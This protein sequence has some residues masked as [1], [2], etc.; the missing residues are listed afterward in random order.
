MLQM[1]MQRLDMLGVTALVTRRVASVAIVALAFVL[2][3]SSLT[4]AKVQ[5]TYGEMVDYQLTFPVDGAVRLSDSFYAA[6]S[7]GDHHAQDL[8]APKMTP[9]VAA[10]A[11]TVRYVNWSRDP[12]NLNP[13]RC[14]TMVIRHDDGW[15]SWYIHLNND[16]PGTDDGQA[17]G[18]ADGIIPG[19]RVTAGQHIG[20][21]GDSG[22]AEGTA[23]HLHFE[24][25]DPDGVI[26]NPYQAL[27]GACGACTTTSTGGSTSTSTGGTTTN[28]VAGPNDTLVLGSRGPVVSEVQSSLATHGFSPGSA[29]GIF[30]GKTFAAV[31]AFQ[32]ARGLL[33]DGKVGPATKAALASEVQAQPSPQQAVSAPPPAAS[34][35]ALVA[36]GTR[37]SSVIDL[38]SMLAQLG[39]DP[40]GVDGA[41]GPLTLAAIKRFQQANGLTD[42][43]TVGQGTWDALVAAAGSGDETVTPVVVYGT[44]SEKVLKL[45]SMLDTLGHA[46]GPVDGIF[47]PKTNAAVGRFQAA[48]G[49]SG[50]LVDQATWDAL[51]AAAG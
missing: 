9:V 43:G 36:Y 22:N 30:G 10:A 37:G 49:F 24:L 28:T 11:G 14:C 4:F 46:P 33:V 13:D 16:T 21:V 27:V 6:R 35:G 34:S 25:Y 19:A 39:H 7:N 5:F 12:S 51:V 40:G 29:D 26:V 17:W 18:L 15:E 41:F 45:Q 20:W 3:T 47:G 32:E 23:S 1:P 44:I 31:L 48:V 2:G 8:M 38:Q 50:G 42:D